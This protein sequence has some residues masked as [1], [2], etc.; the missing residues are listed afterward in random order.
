MISH[1]Y[2]LWMV[3]LKS[4][5]SSV[6]NLQFKEFQLGQLFLEVKGLRK[7]CGQSWSSF[8][9]SQKDVLSENSYRV[10]FQPR[11]TFFFFFF[12][13]WQGF[14]RS[15]QTVLTKETLWALLSCDVT[16]A[17]CVS[18]E[19]LR[20]IH[21]SQVSQDELFC[22]FLFLTNVTF[23]SFFSFFWENTQRA[24]KLFYW[25]LPSR[26]KLNQDQTKSC[27]IFT[28]C[29]KSFN[30][31]IWGA[32]FL[33]LS[34]VNTAWLSYLLKTVWQLIILLDVTWP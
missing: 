2:L 4:F 7:Q 14:I 22:F 31:P 19:A 10:S 30:E 27:F 24:V 28:C 12:T 34:M 23:L 29:C 8:S 26:I 11:G 3:L 33:I 32:T 5:T 18:Q 15:Y 25:N 9:V 16:N 21:N 17:S 6:E 1:Q 20:I 13:G